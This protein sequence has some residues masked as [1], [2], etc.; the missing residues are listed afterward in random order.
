MHSS[1]MRT[2]RLLTV[3]QHV[4][5]GVSATWGVSAW[6][7]LPSGGVSS[8]GEGVSLHAMGQTHLWTDR[9]L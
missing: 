2:A 5:P 6:G 7:C 8:Q 9:H 4:L 1:G 3:S